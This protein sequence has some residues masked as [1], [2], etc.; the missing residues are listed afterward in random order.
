VFPL[1]H[2]LIHLRTDKNKQMNSIPPIVEKINSLFENDNIHPQYDYCENLDD[3]RG[4]TFG[5]IGF[6]TANG[7]GYDLINA[8]CASN[9]NSA[10]KKY[11][12]VL[13]QLAEDED[14]DTDNLV[15][16]EQAWKQEAAQTH[17]VQDKLAFETY[18]QPALTYCQKLGLKSTMA[19]AFLYD[20]IVQHGDGE[21]AD[22]LGALLGRTIEDMGGSLS[23]KDQNGVACDVIKNPEI[24]FLDA[25]LVQ[26]KK[27]LLNPANKDTTDEWRESVERVT[28]LRNLMDTNNMDL[29]GAIQIESK[30]WNAQIA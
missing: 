1:T 13:K 2:I 26:R 15:G 11:L 16:F 9:A 23:G 12:P 10:L 5:K 18:G 22:S 17:A 29:T 8:Y 25:F 4:F 7:D 20:A 24:E 21:D 27:C 3:G 30:D 28:A 19:T 6:T 14:D